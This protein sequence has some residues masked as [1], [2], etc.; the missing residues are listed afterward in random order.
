MIEKL[1]F[2]DFESLINLCDRRRNL[3]FRKLSIS[4]QNIDKAASDEYDAISNLSEKLDKELGRRIA[5]I[6]ESL[7][8]KR[9]EMAD[10]KD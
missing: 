7:N 10:K 3:L 1:N 8:K 6:T 2:S 4:Q 5:Q 9:D